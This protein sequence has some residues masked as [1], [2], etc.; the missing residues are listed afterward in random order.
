M[1]QHMETTT[2]LFLK[3]GSLKHRYKAKAEISQMMI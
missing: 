1:P 3:V 2:N